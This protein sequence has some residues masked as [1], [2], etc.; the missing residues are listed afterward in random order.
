MKRNLNI[1][2]SVHPQMPSILPVLTADGRIPFIHVGN[3]DDQAKQLGLHESLSSNKPPM[4]SGAREFC[5]SEHFN[6]TP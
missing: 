2:L 6:R 1:L 3:G 5:P 4:P